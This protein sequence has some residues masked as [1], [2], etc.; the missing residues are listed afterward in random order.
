MDGSTGTAA[1]VINPAV[2]HKQRLMMGAAETPAPYMN[3][4]GRRRAEVMQQDARVKSRLP[5]RARGTPE[6]D[7]LLEAF[8]ASPMTGCVTVLDH[9]RQKSNYNPMAPTQESIIKFFF[10]ELCQHPLFR[11]VTEPVDQMSFD[12]F[13]GSRTG[14]I[15]AEEMIR[16]FKGTDDEAARRIDSQVRQVMG[17]AVRQMGTAQEM[18]LIQE[19]SLS[20]GDQIEFSYIS[21]YVKIA[22]TMMPPANYFTQAIGSR[23]GLHYVFD[24]ANWPKH[25]EAVLQ[26]QL[27]LVEDW[28]K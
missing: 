12:V 5:L 2:L 10:M 15:S 11:Y 13:V 24:S 6:Y 21:S 20:A 19:H 18:R 28:G 1:G 23:S 8:R 16:K 7:Q 14:Q 27:K 26:L 4:V 25:A 9:L 17:A 3:V 22:V